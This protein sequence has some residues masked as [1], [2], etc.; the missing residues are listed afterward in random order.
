MPQFSRVFPS[1]FVLLVFILGQITA[2]E[3]EPALVEAKVLQGE[4]YTYSFHTTEASINRVENAV[5]SHMLDETSLNF[6]YTLT[7]EPDMDFSGETRFVLERR[8]LQQPINIYTEVVVNVVPSMLEATRDVTVMSLNDSNVVIDALANDVLGHGNSSL[9]AIDLVSDG[10]VNIVDN[11]LVFTKAF[12]FE[13]QTSF[14]YTIEDE[15]GYQSSSVVTVVVGDE[16]EQAGSSLTY[17]TTAVSPVDIYLID[18]SYA[19]SEESTTELGSLDNSQDHVLRYIPKMAAE[20]QESFTLVND[21]GDEISVII[22]V[23]DDGLSSLSVRDDIYFTS[24]GHPISFDPRENDLNQNGILLDY[25]D[26]LTESGGT[27]TFTPIQG[28]SG[29]SSFTYTVLEGSKEITGEIDIHVSDYMPQR[30]EYSFQTTEG[31]AFLLEYLA[32]ITNFSWSVVTPPSNGTLEFNRGSHVY[33]CGVASGNRMTLYDPSTGFTGDDFFVIR[34][35]ID[36]GGPCK[37]VSVN[38]TVL[39]SD[40]LCGCRGNDCVWAGDTDNDGKV[41]VK[42]I[43]AIGCLLYTSPSPRDQR[44]SRMPSSA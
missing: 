34:Y 22:D 28:Y 3:V 38:M 39:P 31:E 29:V 18:P 11:K 6:E 20:G 5:G 26:E 2:Q 4:T 16:E 30:D 40:G 36:D 44:G 42:D 7:Y 41:S 14:N 32:P 9:V 19:I 24:I 23:I 27:L 33:A 1:V 13:G 8:D 15:S 12:G 10:T 35:C 21:N 17:L 43:L 37:D 25:S